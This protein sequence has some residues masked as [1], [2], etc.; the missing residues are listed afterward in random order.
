MH[1]LLDFI[2]LCSVLS[3]KIYGISNE[4]VLIIDQSDCSVCL[5]L[6]NVYDSDQLGL[7]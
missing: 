4:L 6:S 2:L 1:F 7:Y 3:A 5:F